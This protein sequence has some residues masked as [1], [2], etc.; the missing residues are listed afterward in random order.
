VGGVTEANLK[1]RRTLAE[2]GVV[3]VVLLVDANTGHLAEPPDF[4]ARGFVHDDTTFKDV[5]PIIED[6]LA[7][8]AAESIGDANALEELVGR[9]VGNWTWRHW[10]RRPVIIPVV[11]DA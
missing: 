1:D 7:K 8:A 9:A 11:I 5:I 3:T 4:L 10:R 6:T 2:E